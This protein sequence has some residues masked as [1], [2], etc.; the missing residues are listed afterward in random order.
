MVFTISSPRG[1]YAA[2]F[3]T[4]V[5]GIM[6][7]VFDSKFFEESWPTISR[8]L[9]SEADAETEVEVSTRLCRD[10][11]AFG[12]VAWRTPSNAQQIALA[13]VVDRRPGR[14]EIAADSPL[15]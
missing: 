2:D 6:R 5:L 10:Q 3:Y 9:E 12:P 15:A 13:Q 4:P 7:P 1:L 8:G 14:D 11:P